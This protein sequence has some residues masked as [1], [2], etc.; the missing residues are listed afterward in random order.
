LGCGE[1]Q[2]PEDDRGG[3]AKDDRVLRLWFNGWTLEGFEDAKT[4]VIET[5][6]D[7]LRRA[8]PTSTKVGEAARRVLKRVV[9]LKLAKQAGGF[10]FTA[11][12][13]IIALCRE[14]RR[15]TPPTRTAP[16]RYQ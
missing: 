8:R 6:V 5:I 15:A 7:E 10:A 1:I 14:D 9:R 3:L 13:G 11:D 16:W 12:S 2:R 4:V